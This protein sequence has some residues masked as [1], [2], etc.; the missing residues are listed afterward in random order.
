ME[1]RESEGQSPNVREHE[2]T[3]KK[4]PLRRIRKVSHSLNEEEMLAFQSSKEP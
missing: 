3:T 1:R 4:L 2:I